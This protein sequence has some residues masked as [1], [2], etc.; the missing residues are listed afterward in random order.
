[1]SK[2]DNKALEIF[3][4]GI[5][6]ILT[7]IDSQLINTIKDKEI[8]AEQ[9]I[10]TV[11]LTLSMHED[12]CPN[13]DIEDIFQEV[14]RILLEAN[15]SNKS[16]FNGGFEWY[17]KLKVKENIE[18]L[19]LNTKI[20]MHMSRDFQDLMRR[21]INLT[22]GN[23]DDSNASSIAFKLNTTKENIALIND[24]YKTYD[25][26]ASFDS[27]VLR[28]A[29]EITDEY[30]GDYKELVYQL[31]NKANL[32]D[33]E[34][35][36]LLQYYGILPSKGKT[37]SYNN[38]TIILDG[39][40]KNLSYITNLMSM[41]LERGRQLL[42]RTLYKLS[43]NSD[44]LSS[45][46]IEYSQNPDLVLRMHDIH[47]W[48]KNIPFTDKYPNFE[49]YFKEYTKEEIQSVI[50]TLNIKELKFI[51][52][53]IQFESQIIKFNYGLEEHETLTAIIKNIYNS[54]IEKYGRRPMKTNI[55][56]C[57]CTR[58]G[59]G[60]NKLR[61]FYHNFP[62]YSQDDIN[63]I[64]SR[65]STAQRET[66]LQIFGHDL[67]KVLSP[68]EIMKLNP[69]TIATYN[70]LVYRIK[71][72]LK[73]PNLQKNLNDDKKRKNSPKKKQ[74]NKKLVGIY[75]V[76]LI[77]SS[78]MLAELLDGLFDDELSILKKVF[79]ESFTD[80]NYINN[81]ESLSQIELA[82][83]TNNINRLKK[84]CE[85][86]RY[87]ARA[88][89]RKEKRIETFYKMFK[90]YGYSAK[91]V[92]E[93]A[94]TN[95]ISPLIKEYLKHGTSSFRREEIVELILEALHTKK[96]LTLAIQSKNKN[97]TK[98]KINNA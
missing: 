15:Q 71:N 38:V 48:T 62:E 67:R 30:Q 82:I 35:F 59:H 37:V 27:A 61:G 36:L 66:L 29:D 51:K 84:Q 14:Y 65:L 46:L 24:I 1:M 19:L 13:I 26:K 89:I 5:L 17:I 39:K 50:E 23:I 75:K 63:P 86:I 16:R 70:A 20:D 87:E 92:K 3:K 56:P 18:S 45:G 54:L 42:I 55:T 40:P 31:I 93:I 90:I 52:Q 78:D 95:E 32:S 69:K 97:Y 7:K 94:R 74:D 83:Y 76:L 22:Q 81:L 34:L 64:V 21:T 33:A 96:Y 43:T 72:I 88:V 77:T 4:T 68:K 60:L 25:A 41:S 28:D 98:K 73:D 58:F 2:F 85:L 57:E 6:E 11:R 44:I 12:I 47:N 79:G 49:A 8:F 10:N 53:I 91:E 9:I 80:N